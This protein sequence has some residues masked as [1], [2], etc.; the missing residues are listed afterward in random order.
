MPCHFVVSHWFLQSILKRF[1]QEY[2]LELRG[3]AL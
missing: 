2:I 1:Y 3:G